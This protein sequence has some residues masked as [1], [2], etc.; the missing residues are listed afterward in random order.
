NGVLVEAINN[1]FI[2]SADGIPSKEITLGMS[3]GGVYY[4]DN[5][6]PYLIGIEY[7]MD[8]N[9]SAEHF[10]RLKCNTLVF[11]DEIIE[12]NQLFPMI[13]SFLECFSRVKNDVFNFNVAD[14]SNI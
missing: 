5:N 1:K 7:S 11:F 8:G 9:D 10:G 12:K 14:F 4:I 2:L 3:G 13:P 6:S